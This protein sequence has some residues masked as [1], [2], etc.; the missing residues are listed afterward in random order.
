MGDP[1]LFNLGYLEK[2]KNEQSK[3]SKPIRK[4]RSGMSNQGALFGRSE[5]SE[6]RNELRIKLGKKRESSLGKFES[7][8]TAALK[9]KSGLNLNSSVGS[10]EGEKKAKQQEYRP[11]SNDSQ[12][13]Q[14]VRTYTT[15]VP[16]IMK[17]RMLQNSEQLTDN[18]L[19]SIVQL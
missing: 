15:H 7:P 11:P 17:K 16:D 4:M 19:E 6:S 18:Q 13:D 12:T 8:A 9:K 14:P 5:Q 1:K 2:Q 3:A 10:I